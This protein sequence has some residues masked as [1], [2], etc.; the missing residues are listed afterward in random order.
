[1][2][3]FVSTAFESVYENVVAPY[4]EPSRDK[5]L[6]DVPPTLKGREKPTLVI[7]LDGTLIYSQWSRQYGWRY[8]KRPGVDEFL[9]QLAPLYELVLWTESLSSADVVIDKL[10][11]RRLF[12]H[13]LYRDATTFTGGEHKKDL[14]YL[15]RDLNKVIIVD[16]ADYAYSLHPHHGIAVNSYNIDEDPNQED[17]ALKR[18]MPFLIYLAL[19]LR[20]GTA[21]PF[22]EEIQALK[23]PA[24]LEDGGETFQ[25]AVEARFAELRSA[26]K[27]PLQRGRGR[28]GSGGP[29]ANI[30]GGTVWERMGLRKGG[31]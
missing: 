6:P 19:A 12:R 9:A 17:Q 29:E 20:K 13:R 15:N 5:L 11:P 22:N 18:L 21:A 27:L 30:A 3:G 25:K 14:S 16:C 1:M 24:K 26:G 31:S 2:P 28:G 23:V 8:V 4:A 10:D 7:S